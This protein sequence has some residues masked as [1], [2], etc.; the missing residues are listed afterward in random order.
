MFK[1]AEVINLIYINFFDIKKF[2]NINIS[3]LY[4]YTNFNIFL[5]NM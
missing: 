4:S 5:W 2:N 1:L 3:S